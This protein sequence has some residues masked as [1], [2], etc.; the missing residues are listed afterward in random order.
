MGKP[1]FK[2]MIPTFGA[3]EIHGCHR[4]TANTAYGDESNSRPSPM[5]LPTFSLPSLPAKPTP[6]VK[7]SR[8]PPAHQSVLH[9]PPTSLDFGIKN[10]WLLR[11]VARSESLAAN[12][13]H[14][15]DTPHCFPAANF[16]QPPLALFYFVS[17][18]KMALRLPHKR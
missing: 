17:H 10:I 2:R 16:R 1:T 14:F 5:R 8:K 13:L 3:L 9:H 11:L 18:A 6:D 12:A 15:K 4:G 7:A